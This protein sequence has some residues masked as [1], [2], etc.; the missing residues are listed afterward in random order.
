MKRQPPRPGSTRDM[1]VA[2]WSLG[3]VENKGKLYVLTAVCDADVLEQR[4]QAFWYR[5]PWTPS[6]P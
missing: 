3:S 6:T 2:L 5:I 4:G 1:P